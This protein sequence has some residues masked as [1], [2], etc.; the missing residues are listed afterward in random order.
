MFIIGKIVCVQGIID[1]NMAFRNKSITN[2]PTLLRSFCSVFNDQKK[3]CKI[4]ILSIHIQKR[5]YLS[6]QNKQISSLLFNH[7]IYK[8]SVRMYIYY[9]QIPKSVGT[10]ENVLYLTIIIDSSNNGFQTECL[11]NLN[12]CMIYRDIIDFCAI[13]CIFNLSTNISFIIINCCR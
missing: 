8:C 9:N 12:F 10:K 5:I 2:Q 11:T 6:S 3:I 13:F 1:G 4:I 7:R